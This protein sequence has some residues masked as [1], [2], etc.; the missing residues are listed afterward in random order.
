MIWSN[1]PVL[2]WLEL[3]IFGFVF[4][5]WLK[6]DRQ[7]AFKRGLVIGSCFLALFILIRALDGFGNI[8]PRSGDTWIDFLNLVKYPPSLTFTLLT[9]GI[10]LILLWAFSRLTGAWHTVLKPLRVF[11]QEPLFFYI[12]HLYLYAGLGYLLTPDGTSFSVMYPLWIVGLVI[13]YP[14]CA[15]YGRFKSQQSSES[16]FRFL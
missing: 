5:I 4:G 2:P 13:L 3:V 8:R 12:L 6:E 15:W 1:Y 7:K 9:T 16:L 11:G 10:N 14:I